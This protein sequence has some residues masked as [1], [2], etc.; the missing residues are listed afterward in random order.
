MKNPQILDVYSDFLLSSFSIVTATGLS[1]LLDNGYSHDQISRFLAQGKF[2][3]KDF[4]KSVKRLIRQVET[5]TSV[6]IIDDT[7]EE[8]PYTTENEIVAWHF[9]HCTSKMVKGINIVNFLYCSDKYAEQEINLPCAYEIVQ[10]TATYIDEKTGK[11]KRRS[12]IT[13]N[14]MMQER[15]RILVQHNRLNFKY[16][17]WDTWY[18]SQDNL[19]FV[20]YELKKLFVV[21][22]KS[23]RR[24]AL[25][26]SEKRQGKFTKIEELDLQPNQVTEVWIKGLDYPVLAI[27]QI[28]T[29]K[30]GS[31]GELYLI[32]NDLELSYT[33]ICTIY[34]KRWNVESFHKS[35]KQN[36][37]LEKSPTKY[38]VTQSNHIFASMI[39][40]CKLEILK[41][42]E[43]MNH[44]QIKSRL[45]IQAVK[46]AF[47]ELQNLKNKIHNLKINANEQI[48]L[49]P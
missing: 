27:K 17:L 48:L 20:H 11:E 29:N 44:F 46:A 18:S 36:A 13:K 8:K 12:P 14:E 30:D 16:L 35:L 42:K 10:K 33:D 47:N 34:Q 2:D 4:W 21:A 1:Q 38:E 19:D 22:L 24:V 31:T 15:L 9:D 3:N 41:C 26:E 49:I 32:T 25:S 28:F 6:L 23:N 39:A 40:Y 5:A 45:Y 37:A 7:L 43:N